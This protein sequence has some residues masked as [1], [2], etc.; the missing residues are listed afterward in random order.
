MHTSPF[1]SVYLFILG[2]FPCQL[3]IFFVDLCHCFQSFQ[4]PVIQL[5]QKQ[6]YAA[7]KA[8]DI[9]K[10]IKEGRKP[11]PGPPGGDEDLSVPSR[12]SSGEHVNF[13]PYELLQLIH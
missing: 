10:A 4:E 13:I 3:K 7:W 11:I 2:S 9:R 6:K 8:A 5:E 1:F 12:T